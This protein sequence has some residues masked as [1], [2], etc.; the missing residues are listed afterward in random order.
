LLI[1]ALNEKVVVTIDGERRE[2]TKRE[3]V[4]T[5]LVNESTRANLRATKMLTDMLKDA[6]KKAGVAAS[7]EPAP[8]TAADE[9]VMAT[10]I[11]RLRQS[12]EEELQQKTAENAGSLPEG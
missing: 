11:A 2:I 8:F 3:A 7:P 4:A 9:E 1:E 6:E 12:W 5:Q 10:F